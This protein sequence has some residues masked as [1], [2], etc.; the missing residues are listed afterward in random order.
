MKSKKISND[1][2]FYVRCFDSLMCSSPSICILTT[3][4]LRVR[5]LQRK[6]GLS[7]PHPTPVFYCRTFQGDSSVV[8]YSNCQYSSDFCLSLTY[9]QFI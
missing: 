3:A 1:L 6:T 4:E 9:F 8:V 5:L 2:D 7:T